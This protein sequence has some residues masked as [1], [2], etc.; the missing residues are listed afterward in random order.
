[1]IKMLHNHGEHFNTLTTRV[2]DIAASTSIAGAGVA[3][4]AEVNAWIQI[5]AGVVAVIAG[6]AAAIFHIYKT[7][8]LHQSRK[9][10]L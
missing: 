9:D 8:D 5:A 4:L 7:Y 2:A 3:W 1:M 6:L 10:T